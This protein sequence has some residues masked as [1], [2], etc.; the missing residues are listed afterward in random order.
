M[1]DLLLD[2]TVLVN[3]ERSHSILDTVVEDDDDVAIAAISCGSP[4]CEVNQPCVCWGDAIMRS[5]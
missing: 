1:S 2:T 4:S 3:I 5:V